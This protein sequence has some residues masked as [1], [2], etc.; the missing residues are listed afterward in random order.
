MKTTE[1]KT[2]RQPVVFALDNDQCVWSRAGV[3]KP[4]KCIN[5]FD[6]LGCSMDQR[7]LTNFDEKRKAAGTSDPRPARML[8]LMNQGKCRHMLSG[9]IAFGYCSQGY[10]C[11]KCPF[12]QMI[13]ES[14]YLPNLHPP[15]VDH[16]SGFKVARDH[17][18]H[19]GHTWARVEY[20]GRVRIGIDDFALRLLGPQDEIQ[21]PELGSTVG[22]NRP[23]AVLKRSGKEAPTLSPVD[24]KVVAINHKVLNKTVTANRDPYGEGWLMV[25]QPSS[26][27]NNLK[28]L[29][30]G[31]ES[32]AWID[33]EFFSLQKLMGEA[34]G[35]ERVYPM[36][37]TGGEA[38]ADIYG[39]VP[40]L[41]WER[42]VNT[43]LH[44]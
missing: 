2:T 36:A 23:N 21:T 8:L 11:V 13:E 28:N 43:F 20:G 27:R 26:L 18:Y 9:R 22:Q 12:D 25:I 42:L 41:G 19:F 16:A 38:L 5:A 34:L 39:E 40:Q 7:V 1:Q 15:K 37:A 10:N 30:F 35:E 4:A 24:G 33:D 3:I 14:S 6:C 32:L 17:Y 44:T 31:K 29:F